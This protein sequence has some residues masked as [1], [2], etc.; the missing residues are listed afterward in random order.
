MNQFT[1]EKTFYEMFYKVIRKQILRSMICM[2]KTEYLFINVL[3]TAIMI[4][5]LKH[6]EMLKSEHI[7]RTVIN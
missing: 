2:F 4:Q 7:V 6:H 1:L 3:Y 5:L